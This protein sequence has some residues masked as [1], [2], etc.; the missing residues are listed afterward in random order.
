MRRLCR[1]TYGGLTL[2]MYVREGFNR[3]NLSG[4]DS[5]VFLSKDPPHGKSK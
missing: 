1:D 4:R 2:V 5:F 3:M